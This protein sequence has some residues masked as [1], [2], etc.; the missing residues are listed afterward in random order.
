MMSNTKAREIRNGAGFEPSCCM[1][2]PRQQEKEK[3]RQE[4][5][6][7][8]NEKGRKK[9]EAQRGSEIASW[10]NKQRMF[11]VGG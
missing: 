7:K 3:T 6:G 11:D 2:K 10:Q 4:A 9:R 8:I 5:R 1:K